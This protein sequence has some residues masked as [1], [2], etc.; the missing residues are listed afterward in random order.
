MN[1]LFIYGNGGFGHEVF[2]VATRMSNFHSISFIDDFTYDNV[3]VFNSSYVF[4]NLLPLGSCLF[5]VAIG[6]IALRNNLI[7]RIR[8]HGGEFAVLI[9]PTAVVSP[10]ATVSEGTIICQLAFIGP[11]VKIGQFVIVNSG[12][13]IG[14]D[15]VV[16]NNSVISSGAKI[17]GKSI[18]SE[19]VYLGMGCVVKEGLKI[20]RRAVLGM[21][22]VLH[23]DLD[24]YMLAIGNPAR[25]M[26]KIDDDFKILG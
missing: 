24:S 26:R 2:D 8:D 19:N 18:I 3:N 12:A 15:I 21:G 16:G 6:D 7:E 25:V 14:H 9:D 20:D 22:A 5:A 11:E 1:R 17:G 4:E 23:S 13:I 10:S